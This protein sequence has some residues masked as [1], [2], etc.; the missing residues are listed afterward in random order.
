MSCKSWHHSDIHATAMSPVRTKLSA[1]LSR[2][3]FICKIFAE[4]VL[5]NFLERVCYCKTGKCIPASRHMRRQG[6]CIQANATFWQNLSQGESGGK[7]YPNEPKYVPAGRCIQAS[8]QNVLGK[9]IQKHTNPGRCIL[10]QESE[11]LIEFGRK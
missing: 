3:I 8:T 9:C 7:I 11:S 5:G 4:L 1:I 6:R 2:N 10:R